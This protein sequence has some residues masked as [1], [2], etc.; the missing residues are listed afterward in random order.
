MYETLDLVLS[1]YEGPVIAPMTV[2]ESGYF[3]ETVGRLRDKGHD[4]HHFA[5]LARPET[6]LRRLKERGLW[7]LRHESFA[8]DQVDRCLSALQRPEFA[9]HIHTDDIDITDVADRIAAAAGL[10]LTPNTDGPLRKRLR[11]AGVGIKH[12][13]F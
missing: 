5:L 6:V 3:A 1:K 10:T 11:R 8:V 7:G 9:E 4:V 12:I 13:R 2:V